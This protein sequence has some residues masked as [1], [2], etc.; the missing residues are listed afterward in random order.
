MD[1]HPHPPTAQSILQALLLKVAPFSFPPLLPLSRFLIPLSPTRLPSK[2]YHQALTLW[3][4]DLMDSNSFKTPQKDFKIRLLPLLLSTVV[5]ESSITVNCVSQSL[6]LAAALI[7]NDISKQAHARLALKIP[8][9][10]KADVLEILLG[11]LVNSTPVL[12]F[13]PKLQNLWAKSSEEL[14]ARSSTPR[15]LLKSLICQLLTIIFRMEL[16][17]RSKT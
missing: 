4:P 6:T 11:P 14:L 9:V 13:F 16:I 3:F 1:P 15:S 10:K 5:M 8:S 7:A 17:S 12:L 2:T